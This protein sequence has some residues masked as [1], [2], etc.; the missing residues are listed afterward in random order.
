ME[1]SSGSSPN[2]RCRSPG[3]TMRPSATRECGWSTFSTSSATGRP[4]RRIRTTTTSFR[5]TTICAPSAPAAP[6]SSSGW[7]PR[8]NTRS[9]TTSPSRRMITK[10]G[11]ISAST[12]SATTT[13]G[14][15]TASPGT[16][17]TG[18]SGTSRMWSRRCGT[19]QSKNTA[20]FM[21]S[22]QR[23]SRRASPTSK[24]A[25]RCWRGSAPAA[26]TKTRASSSAT[27]GIIRCRWI[28]SPGTAT[29][30]ISTKSS[31]NRR[32][33]GRFWTS[34]AS[35]TPNCTLPNGTT[36]SRDLPKRPIAT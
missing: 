11:P 17:A 3:C 30:G 26:T 18:R 31:R 20:A 6:T 2:W 21:R 24:S 5:P 33:C 34:T 28:S 7:G 12:S 13:K 25:V 36:G 22:R 9:T 35:P 32:E 10:N 1:N 27:A 4:M 23:E 16:S 8:S 29:P 14:G 19:P 15:T